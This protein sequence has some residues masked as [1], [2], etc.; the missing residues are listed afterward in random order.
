MPLD[1]RSPVAHV[2]DAGGLVRRSP[3]PS[4][5][6]RQDIGRTAGPGDQR[7]GPR[8]AGD[9]HPTHIV[10]EAHHPLPTIGT[11]WSVWA[12]SHGTGLRLRPNLDDPDVLALLAEAAP[13]DGPA[14][15]NAARRA[16]RDPRPAESRLPSALLRPLHAVRPAVRF[17][18]RLP[19]TRRPVDLDAPPVP[20]ATRPSPSAITRPGAQP[21]TRPAPAHPRCCT[22]SA[23]GPATNWRSLTSIPHDPSTERPCFPFPDPPPPR[24]S[25]KRPSCTRCVFCSRYAP[26]T[27]GANGRCCPSPI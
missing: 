9:A 26:D 7:P 10:A 16:F 23:T 13:A 3:P 19:E 1:D 4:Q 27:A 15:S 20:T 5:S 24:P 6:R 22:A 11:R 8:P 12:S 21:T 25:T 2:L 14:V 18:D 17:R